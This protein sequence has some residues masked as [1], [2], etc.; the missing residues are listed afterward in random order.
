MKLPTSVDQL[1]R[2]MQI[3]SVIQSEVHEAEHH[4][5][6]FDKCGHYFEVNLVL[7]LGL[8]AEVVRNYPRY[9]LP[10][11]LRLIVVS[12]NRYE[13]F[14][15]C[16]R[17]DDGVEKFDRQPSAQQRLIARYVRQRRECAK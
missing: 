16:S 13:H 1:G 2:I 15:Q 9:C 6:K 7:R 12:L 5:V 3:Q 10:F 8:E 14:A 17:R 4:N 11:Y